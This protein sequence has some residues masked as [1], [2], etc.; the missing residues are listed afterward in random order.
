VGQIVTRLLGWWFNR[1]IIHI[2]DEQRKPILSEEIRAEIDD[3][4]EQY[5]RDNLPIERELLELDQNEDLS[6]KFTSHMFVEQLRLLDISE[7]RILFAILDYYRAS[8]QRSKWLRQELLMVGELGKYEAKLTSEWERRFEQM[9]DET[10]GTATE[11][12]KRELARILYKWIE[13]DASFPIRER[14]TEAFVTRGT[15]QILSNSHRVGWHPE[16]KERLQ[17]LLEGLSDST[18]A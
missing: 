14:C 11:D 13:T 7:R 5:H 15:Y 8:V 2:Y 17:H 10:G 16:F 9:R 3:L 6:S 4:R 12:R 1:S 18:V